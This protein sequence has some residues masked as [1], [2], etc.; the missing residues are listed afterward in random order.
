M[1]FH[2]QRKK[3]QM[4][5]ASPHPVGGDKLT[6]QHMEGVTDIN[7]IMDRHMRTG[8]FGSGRPNGRQPMFIEMTGDSY[9]EMLIK[10][11]QAQGVF[12]AQPAKIRKRFGNNPENLFRFL[13]D[14]SNLREAI[15]LGLVDETKIP[16]E[17]RQQMD[18][19]A[20]SEEEER[21]Q[22]EEWRR[23]QRSL[24][25]RSGEDDK[26]PFTES[27]ANTMPRKADPESQPSFSRKKRTS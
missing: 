15:A 14:R 22:F 4:G 6:Q 23:Q 26:D 19:V 5:K 9:H 16:A 13:E 2:K 21:K 18:L 20:A 8:V 25:R 27:E 12:A 1:L 3:V 7:K 24:K 17:E 10:V 11:Q